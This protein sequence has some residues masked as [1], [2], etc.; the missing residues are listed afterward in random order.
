MNR[1]T[2]VVWTFLVLGVGCKADPDN[3]P[4]PVPGQEAGL[5]PRQVVDAAEPIPDGNRDLPEG[6]GEVAQLRVMVDIVSPM[7][8][9]VVVAADR[10]TPSVNVTVDSAN[11]T[12]PDTVSDVTAIVTKLGAKMSAATAKLSE[13][14]LEQVPESPVAIHRFTDTPV[15]LSD[16]ESG[17]YELKVTAKTLSGI[18]AEASL[19]FQ[20]D[21]GPIV[22]ID[23]PGENKYYRNS[24]TIDVT[25]TDPQFGVDKV[26][27]LLG[28]R[29]LMFSG[30]SGAGNSQYT[31]TIDFSSFDPPLEGD[32]LLTVR[33]TNKKG[34][35]TVVRRKFISDNKGP[36]IASTIPSTGSLIG[37][38][39][40]IS[41]QVTDPAGVL[42]SSVVAVV[43]HGDA[44]FEVKLE[45][46]PVGASTPA[47]TYH[48]LFDTARLP[49]EALFPS[50]SFRAS[51]LPGNQSSVGYLVS[52]DNTPPLADLDPPTEFHLVKLQDDVLRCSWPFDP[53]GNDAINDGGN[54]N[55]LF[56]IRARIEDQGNRPMAGG[57]DFTPISG[58][59]DN[60][61]HLL[62][63]DDTTKALVVDTN[64][65]G[66]CDAINPL[67]TPTTT[68]MSA[69]DA[70][71]VNMAPIPVAGTANYTPS[72]PFAGSPCVSGT[73]T[74]APDPLCFT[75]N[76]TTTI[77][78]VGVATPA[79]YTIPPV[80]NDRAQ[81]V[82]RQFDSLGNSVQDGWVCLA[83]SVSDR[84]GNTQVSRPLRVCID[85]DGNGAECGASRAPMPNC[86]GTQTSGMPNITINA[87]MPC[88]PW[89]MYAPREYRRVQ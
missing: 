40:T 63:L 22:R 69:S 3:F 12:D 10:F 45:P 57:T 29:T 77:S 6:G 82:G 75:T 36:T 71:L 24:V 68:P 32:Q 41:A 43:A 37:R 39:I 14:K 56:D 18:M 1:R 38:V 19:N 86:T 85:K 84:L 73:D 53:L 51:D 26:S 72:V 30:P 9:A 21:A 62:I 65:D 13:T 88:N 48:A 17:I 59:N 7:K 54:T 81:C 15:D 25:V 23:S 61:V 79:I 46:A 5:P 42:E 28:Q 66:F 70:L 44:M 50:V 83:V 60:Q 31:G 49:A 4:T 80:L 89:R 20:V 34:T 76:L 35:E 16:L 8:D 11:A 74:K 64:K 55:Q 52:L 33:A 27:M 58:I 78:Y 47:G 67:L 87:A 2:Q